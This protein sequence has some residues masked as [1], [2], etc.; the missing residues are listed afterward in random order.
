MPR[1]KLKIENLD[2]Q[3]DYHEKLLHQAEQGLKETKKKLNDTDLMISLEPP[4]KEYSE[5]KRWE[6]T[7]E[8]IM[9]RN[10]NLQMP[11]LPKMK[12]E[13]EMKKLLQLDATLTK[14]T[15]SREAQEKYNDLIRERKTQF[16]LKPPLSPDS[17]LTK[18]STF[19]R[20]EYGET[21]KTIPNYQGC[22]TIYHGT[23]ELLR[24]DGTQHLKDDE[25]RSLPPWF[26]P[27]YYDHALDIPSFE[28]K[29]DAHYQLAFR[30]ISRGQKKSSVLLEREKIQRRKEDLQRT[31]NYL[32]QLHYF[33]E[34][35]KLTLDRTQS[36]S[37]SQKGRHQPS[38]Q[39]LSK[40][41]SVQELNVANIDQLQQSATSLPTI[42]LT[43]KERLQLDQDDA[44]L[45]DDQ[46]VMSND[47]TL[48]SNNA[49][50]DD[51]FQFLDQQTNNETARRQPS[52][53][54]PPLTPSNSH[55][56]SKSQ[57]FSS[58]NLLNNNASMSSASSTTTNT[59][60]TKT[61]ADSSESSSKLQNQWQQLNH[62][63][64]VHQLVPNTKANRRNNNKQKA[65]TNAS[66]SEVPFYQPK[67]VPFDP[68]ISNH[69]YELKILHSDPQ[70][71]REIQH[72]V[73]HV[74]H[75]QHHAHLQNPTFH[76]QTHRHHHTAPIEKKDQMFY[77]I[78][79]NM[80][81]A[82]EEGYLPRKAIHTSEHVHKKRKDYTLH[83][84]TY[85]KPLVLAT[86]NA[87]ESVANSAAATNANT[88][89]S[90]LKNSSNSSGLAIKYSSEIFKKPQVEYRT[91]EELIKE[92]QVKNFSELLVPD[93]FNSVP[94]KGGSGGMTGAN[95]SGIPSR[96]TVPSSPATP[97][98][99]QDNIGEIPNRPEGNHEETSSPSAISSLKFQSPTEVHHHSQRPYGILATY[100]MQV[101]ALNSSKPN[102]RQQS[103]YRKQRTTDHSLEENSK[104][105]S[106]PP[107]PTLNMTKE[108]F[109]ESKASSTKLI[110]QWAK[111]HHIHF[112]NHEQLLKQT[113][114]G[115]PR[116]RKRISL[117]EEI[118]ETGKMKHI[119][120][121]LDEDQ[122]SLSG[123][124]LSDG[125]VIQHKDWLESLTQTRIPMKPIHET[126]SI[127]MSV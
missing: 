59:T 64:S 98:T 34:H 118:E 115:I 61:Q 10:V 83:A 57:L 104:F 63:R 85:Q 1:N 44:N 70:F 35:D 5:W 73:Q 2:V 97:M 121:E 25:D 16:Q 82:L 86:Y 106:G 77:R 89:T 122:V 92:S 13:Y 20:S 95:R 119:N 91:A 41:F 15:A 22:N 126:E 80:N 56:I 75:Y 107:S 60:T 39:M 30:S 46:S 84:L 6:R 94:G 29:H 113:G 81:H 68:I 72:S 54:F 102:S 123:I 3:L 17:S 26:H 100:G 87:Q 21:L 43:W 62:L 66:S 55:N 53:Q 14:E 4:K 37:S 27:Q 88:T 47:S 7:V 79:R 48:S 49:V 127:D 11:N 116:R 108:E 65:S 40:P 18:K 52:F 93:P 117:K 74:H 78:S 32:T 9:N 96:M 36:S 8:R 99:F 105:E 42:S 110:R 24:K 28:Q 120:W 101:A 90:S 12:K 69:I 71:R 125:E 33:K 45:V 103:R 23:R 58:S 67:P 111:Y 124:L 109:L 76:S 38:Q 19:G 31:A 50:D 51:D 114:C 112:P